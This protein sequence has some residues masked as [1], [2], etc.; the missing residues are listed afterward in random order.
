[1][2]M[3]QHSSEG[4]PSPE[5]TLAALHAGGPGALAELLGDADF[6]LTSIAT[7]PK[8]MFESM[9]QSGAKPV[10]R[11]R[12]EFKN[13]L[14]MVSDARSALDA[15]EARTVVALAE[16]TVRDQIHAARNDA[17][18]EDDALP[19]CE[20]LLR[21]A[22]ATTARDLSFATR[23]S[24][25]AAKGTVAS[26]RRLVESMPRMLSSLANGK[27]TS[28][29]AHATASASAPL[30]DLQRRQVDEIL[31]ERMPR[32]DGAGV[33]R[34]RKAV[35]GVIGELDPHGA[36]ARHQA[37]RKDRHVSFTEGE[38]G[39]ATVSAHLPAL[40][41]KLAHKRLSLEAERRR[42]DGARV[43]HGALMADA[44]T[45][46]LLGREGG[47]EP[48]TLELGVM[49]T[50]RALLSP[51][52]GDV[53]HIEGYGPVPA[54]AVREELRTALTEPADPAKDRLGPDGPQLRVVMRRL[55]THPT[56]GELVAVESRG[57]EFPPAMKRFLNWRDGTCRAPFCDAPVRQYDHIVPASEG[58]ATAADN[59]QGTCAYCNLSKGEDAARVERIEDPALPGHLVAWTGHGGTT[60]VSTAP[61]LGPLAPVE[62][63]RGQH[64][65]GAD[66]LGDDALVEDR[67]IDDSESRT[68]ALGEAR[69]ATGGAD[70]APCIGNELSISCRIPKGEV[71]QPAG[72]PGTTGR[73]HLRCARAGVRGCSPPST[74]TCARR[75]RAPSHRMPP[76][77]VSLRHHR[78]RFARVALY[79]ERMIRHTVS[80]TLAHAPD[81]AA[82]QDFLTQ[83]PAL[84]REIDGV[85]DFTVSRQVSPKSDYRFQFAMT[86]ADQATFDAYD[87]HPTHQ[88]FVA[89][90]WQNEVS[91]FEELDFIAYP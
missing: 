62:D 86:F 36:A 9:A 64:T 75:R 11:P 46:T 30:D 19:P 66:G 67:N 40:D 60:V 68:E 83:A 90:R 80:F 74:G 31:F 78:T 45:D 59:G 32:M 89:T 4:S 69:G 33:K 5:E 16:A 58:G 53:A 47:M 20:R 41:A 42:A 65:P 82:E 43:G 63:T 70:V 29:V 13:L 54:E 12:S 34:W 22:D 15:I 18:H 48:V 51:E 2:S 55:Y 52:H 10:Q 91:A 26:A 24:S 35:A 72:E 88:K 81:S 14:D 87:A 37:A 71:A 85:E 25:S 50:D 49:I 76:R 56:T 27:V 39:M 79:C 8:A 6:L 38:H 17:A 73:A 7:A 1:M 77:R 84:L 57:R 61:A 28:A 44:F 3:P 21:Q 23:R